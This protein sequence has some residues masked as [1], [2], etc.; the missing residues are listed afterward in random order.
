MRREKSTHCQLCV[1]IN[2]IAPTTTVDVIVDRGKGREFMRMRWGLVPH[3]A[4]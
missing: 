2:N 3:P 1:K 4:A